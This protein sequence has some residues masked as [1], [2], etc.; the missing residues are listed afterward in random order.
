MVLQSPVQNSQLSENFQTL[1]L[2]QLI[3]KFSGTFMMMWEF[4]T[5]KQTHI[6]IT[7]TDMSNC[8]TFSSLCFFPFSVVWH[9][10]HFPLESTYE[11]GSL[12]G[13]LWESG[14]W[15]AGSCCLGICSGFKADRS[16]ED[17][18][19]LFRPYS[20]GY[21]SWES[22]SSW[23]QKPFPEM[24]PIF[25][26]TVMRTELSLTGGEKTST[27]ATQSHLINIYYIYLNW[28]KLSDICKFNFSIQIWS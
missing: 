5:S 6:F 4:P 3:C 8:T 19:F 2:W 26:W 22:S 11:S 14:E 15:E 9:Q 10:S 25:V 24:N 17:L 20:P 27:S 7:Q 16:N 13:V 23:V 1:C 12:R 28:R 21:Q 18:G